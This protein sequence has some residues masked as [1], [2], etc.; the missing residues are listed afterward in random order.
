MKNISRWSGNEVLY[1]WNLSRSPILFLLTNDDS[2]P[3]Y[4]QQCGCVACYHRE[5][6]G[7][8]LI[9]YDDLPNDILSMFDCHSKPKQIKAFI[10]DYSPL[11]NVQINNMI[12]AFVEGQATL[13]DAR[14]NFVLTWENC[15]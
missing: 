8:P 6:I 15:D 7:I 1:V 11:E 13:N 2:Y 3:V 5:F 12:E 4:F 9:I 10:E 14:I